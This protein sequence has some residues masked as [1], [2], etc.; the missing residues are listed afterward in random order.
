MQ[1]KLFL[2]LSL[3]IGFLCQDATVLATPSCTTQ[4]SGTSF[5]PKT[6]VTS[7]R[8][9]LENTRFTD[10]TA[11]S[12]TTFASFSASGSLGTGEYT[13]ATKPSVVSSSYS[14]NSNSL[15]IGLDGKKQGGWYV[16]FSYSLSDLIV[17]KT[18]SISMTFSN[19][20]SSAP[21]CSYESSNPIRLSIQQTTPSSTKSTQI[22]WG[23]T[24]TYTAEFTATS[25]RNTINI[26]DDHSSGCAVL[27]VSNITVTGCSEQKIV[28]ENGEKVCAGS[29]NMLVAKGLSATTYK[30]EESVDGGVTWTV[31]PQTDK[32][33]T[34]LTTT[35][36][37]YRVTANGTNLTPIT[38]RPMICCAVAGNR[39]IVASEHFTFSG[40]STAR[41]GT[42][43]TMTATHA[44]PG[45][46]TYSS[47][48]NVNEGQYVI[49]HSTNFT[50]C[51]YWQDRGVSGN[52]SN[53]ASA[54]ASDKGAVDGFL[55]VNANVNPDIFYEQTF[56]GG[57]KGLCQNTIYDFSAF[58][59]NACTNS[60]SSRAPVNVG[61]RVYGCNSDGSICNTTTPL[62]NVESG[63]LAAGTNW[64]EK[65]GSFNSG[66]YTAF[67]V[68]LYNNL[69]A[70]PYLD[71]DGKVIGNDIIIDDISF[72]TCAPEIQVFSNAA[73]TQ[74]DSTFTS[75]TTDRV[76]V[77][78]PYDLTQFFTSPW[79]VIQ[80]SADQSTWTT[81]YS[82]TNSYTDLVN[83][84]IAK[85]KNKKY[86]YRAFVAA[87]KTTA[88]ARAT[89]NVLTGC[90]QVSGVSDILYLTLANPCTKTTAPTVSNY[91]QCPSASTC[92]LADL[93]TSTK[94]NLRWYSA[95][96]GGTALTATTFDCHTVGTTTYYVTNQFPDAGTTTYCESDRT[97]VTVT[98]KDAVKYSVDKTDI[99]KCL[100]AS[101]A[102]LTFTV[103]N[104]VP[105]SS[106]ISWNTTPATTGDT[107]TLPKT[108]G[109]GSIIITGSDPSAC[110]FPTT[111]TYKLKAVPDFS[112]TAPTIVCV[113]NPAATITA[114]ITTDET[115]STYTWYKSGTQVGTGTI[116]SGTTSIQYNDAS[117]A[118]SQSTVTYKLVINNSICSTEKTVDIEVGT[119]VN[120]PIVSSAAA[121][122][123]SICSGELID[124][125]AQITLNAG[126]SLQWEKDGVVLS[127]TGTTLTGQSLSATTS[128]AITLINAPCPG[129]GSKTIY[130]S[131]PVLPQLNI[132]ETVIC[133][134]SSIDITD[135]NS[136]TAE[137]YIWYE[138]PT[139]TT[140]WTKMTQTSKD[141][142]G[143]IPTVSTDYRKDAYNGTC[144]R[145]SNVVSITVDA[146]VNFT[147][148]PN[149]TICEGNNITITMSNFPVG[150]ITE[151]YNGAI[152][153]E[154]GVST[155][156]D[157]IVTT[158][159]T[160][161]VTTT[162][163]STKDV[164]ITVDPTV[165]PTI[166]SP[167]TICLGD[168][169]QL[170]A[171]GGTSY[172]WSPVT[173]L[174]NPAI[175][176]PIASP[177]VTTI[178]TVTVTGGTCSNVAT[179][180][181]TVVPLPIINSIEETDKRE[182]TVT[183]SGG[184]SPYQYSI[185]NE[186]FFTGNVLSNIAIGGHILYVIDANGCAASMP[187]TVSPIPII[188]AKFFTPNNDGV[189]DYWTIT[190]IECYP[191]SIIQIFDRFGKKIYE[192]RSGQ[193][194]AE[195]IIYSD[196][197]MWDGIYQGHQLPSTDY[198]YLITLE[199]VRKQ[200]SGHFTLKR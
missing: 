169:T 57:G 177:K 10:P 16:I 108:A 86:Y 120:I 4:F 156:V 18:Y 79:Y 190:N 82:G 188:P 9:E 96:T 93:V 61:F 37:L 85:Y 171:T 88:E 129:S 118:T 168:E 160:A 50:G 80:E 122:H 35:E 66:S 44:N 198:W 77:W 180:T 102:E 117:V 25:T 149:S 174:N 49:V 175:S 98:V 187:F 178:Y 196:P 64:L 112:V 121:T 3:I 70:T 191:S 33:I 104:K 154:S 69:V 83:I 81:I 27:G 106:T 11:E 94:E 137:K 89:G 63:D 133:Q 23:K 74:K 197:F 2:L 73:Y 92:N 148:T 157:P 5:L 166:S 75:E 38:V 111:V 173:G 56:T 22:D 110:D 101:D 141:I 55:L 185:N 90:G 29:E 144:L 150:A 40:A 51:T 199:E 151:W 163:T 68:Q 125:T 103:S 47:S 172:S 170:S 147:V 53:V 135:S 162:C 87:D 164:T 1:K 45:S 28:S 78:A 6:G 99:T 124:L 60:G 189:N 39:T 42:T 139:G 114:T 138:R 15:L 128:Y 165:V 36:T 126:E 145:Q 24:Y 153:L 119:T 193:F 13:V 146:P 132:S 113:S 71:K 91:S 131:N 109:S 17:G 58:V 159:Y 181:V 183:V 34:T 20:L 134:G 48:G 65:G 100:S 46:V 143:L 155:T 179:T 152:L 161:K 142:I 136:S 123:D 167:T 182:V 127:E 140:T 30:W 184:A 200:Y 105:A 19:V 130:V 194:N 72:S 8:Y 195:G 32:S 67:K 186:D 116:A 62:L 41:T 59:G 52:T 54:S 76:Y 192:R 84:T 158:T 12:L 107:Y 43:A 7:T 21:T 26:Y 14:G 115:G 176:N 95:A 31:I 97:L